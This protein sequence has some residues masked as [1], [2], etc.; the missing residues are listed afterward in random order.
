MYIPNKLSMHGRIGEMHNQYAHKK[1]WKILFTLFVFVGL[2]EAQSTCCP[3]LTVH[4]SG[5]ESLNSSTI[6]KH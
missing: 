4:F 1:A 5:V 6:H 2:E 3:D